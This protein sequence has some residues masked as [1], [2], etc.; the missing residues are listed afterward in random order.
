MAVIARWCY[1]H[2]YL[3]VVLW[4]A[5]LAVL[6]V[7]SRV[8]GSAY[9]NAFA[10]PGTES[11]RALDL[12]KSAFPQQA[13][14]PDAIVWH[15]SRGSVRDP[16][17]RQ[18]VSA[19]LG[20]VARSASVAGVAS[21][22]THPGAGRVSRDGRTAYAT[23]TF[24]GIGDQVP[25]ADVKHVVSLAQQARAAGLQVELGGQAIQASDG[26]PGSASQYVGIAGAGIVLLIALGSL[27]AMALPLVT[28]ILALIAASMSI[29][30]LSHAMT[31]PDIAPIIA[32]LIGLG[33]GID[34]ALFVVTRHR[35]G[36]KAG[37][38]PQESAVRAL[39]TSGRAVIFAGATVCIAMLGLLV[40]NLGFLTGIGAAAAIMVVFSVTAATTLLP[41]L[42]G[43]LGNR[44]LSR[45]E[46][47]KLAAEGPRDVHARGVWYRWARF[48]ERRPGL[49]AL[50][51]LPVI[52]ALAIPVFSLRLGSSD[53][54]N[55]PASTTTRKTYDL[56]ADGFGPGFNGPLQ[57]VATTGS[58][59][60]ATA[61]AALAALADT[62][63]HTP[64]VATA[65]PLAAKPGSTVQVI[66]VIPATSPQ[67]DRTSELI[68]RLREQ[69][70]PAAE[71]GTTLKV[72]V[73]GPTAMFDDFTH[74]IAGRLPLFLGV[75]V[76]LSFLL[77]LAAF[78]SLVIPLT[79]AVM[80]L[81]AAGAAFGVVIAFFQ[82][83][84]GSHALGLGR[85]GPIEPILPV[86][87]LAILFGLSMDYQVFL[88]SRMHEEWA[89]THRNRRAVT[90]G[91]AATGRVI[92][93]AATIM[94][95]VFLSFVFGGQRVV[96]E[97][98]FGLAAAVFLDAFVLRTMLV[99]ALMH[100]FGRANWWLPQ[101]IGRWLP[102]L[103]V[104]PA[105]DDVPGQPTGENQNPP[106]C[107]DHR[108]AAPRWRSRCS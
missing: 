105:E 83:G 27:F 66:Q 7:G 88:V 6:G 102:H 90:T 101:R 47:R 23:V 8:A 73:G 18:R 84:W 57:L 53:Q 11:A 45:R 82:W 93:A 17:V 70:M 63:T 58:P 48:T 72:Y 89:R 38:S 104:E 95:C 28:A 98:G 15:V 81:L 79:A 10:L 100:T 103:S 99:P 26:P 3:V 52:V 14:E 74:V 87:M 22:Y 40:L 71:K 19:M 107:I 12:L 35:A 34:Y 41:A 61:L 44:V 4:V 56:L 25:A 9:D 32:A 29:S 24:T 51:A 68:T 86:M 76:G 39:N 59:G 42:L 75:I 108:R 69:T 62:V 60:D 37:L 16:L 106:G 2:K 43:I 64:G 97:F 5:A 67:D 36:L 96:A 46:R 20:Q 50:V 92:T 33:V 80:N 77:L 54:G 49:L 31:I 55:N 91:Q 65:V 21:P 30:L 1:Q 94:I 13:G 85:A 78:R